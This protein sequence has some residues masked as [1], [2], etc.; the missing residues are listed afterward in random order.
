MSRGWTP[1]LWGFSYYG[2]TVYPGECAQL[3]ISD[4]FFDAIVFICARSFLPVAGAHA[5]SAL[6]RAVP[7]FLRSFFLAVE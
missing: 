5:L 1:T 6:D 3:R 4:F 7:F 2:L